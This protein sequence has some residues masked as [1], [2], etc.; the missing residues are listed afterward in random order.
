MFVLF[1]VKLSN[2]VKRESLNLF[3]P[4]NF[5]KSLQKWNLFI[6]P[7]YMFNDLK[8][9]NLTESNRI[10]MSALEMI[11]LINTLQLKFKFDLKR[12]LYIVYAAN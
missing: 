6:R 9:W 3:E 5:G 12:D 4:V 10:T 1:G 7:L 2:F 11:I 8:N